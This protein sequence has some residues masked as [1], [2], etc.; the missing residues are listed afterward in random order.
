[1]GSVLAEFGFLLGS[2]V[3]GCGRSA[4]VYKQMRS[5]TWHWEQCV[6][7][8]PYTEPICLFS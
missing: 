2:N 3:S 6:V 4:Y 1:M 7:N 8:F 5:F